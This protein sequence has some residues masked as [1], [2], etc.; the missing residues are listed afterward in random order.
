MAMLRFVLV[1]KKTR[2]FVTE[3]F[4]FKGSVDDWI[5]IDGP[6][7]LDDQVGKHLK[8]VGRESFFD[9]F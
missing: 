1:D 7:G 8:H 6:A 3:R 5:Y 2:S 4:C 9:L